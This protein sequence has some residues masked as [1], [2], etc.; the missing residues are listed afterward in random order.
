MVINLNP[1]RL[2]QNIDVKTFIV[3][4]VFEEELNNPF[5][6]ETVHH[7]RQMHLIG[8]HFDRQAVQFVVGN[9]AVELHRVFQLLHRH[10]QPF[11]EQAPGLAG[12]TYRFKTARLQSGAGQA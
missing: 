9:G 7:R 1:V 6:G 11:E 3:R 4:G 10:A 5:A 2:I 12:N 8:F